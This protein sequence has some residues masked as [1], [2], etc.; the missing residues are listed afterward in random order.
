MKQYTS[1]IFILLGI[2]VLVLGACSDY[3]EK[4]I[5]VSGV[6]DSYVV[7]GN[8]DFELT[9]SLDRNDDVTI[10]GLWDDYDWEF[11]RADLDDRG[12]GTIDF[13]IRS[14]QV[15]GGPRLWGEGIWINGYFQLDYKIDWGPETIRYRM[16]ANQ[17]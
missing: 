9:I 14:Q 17:Y 13:D 15:Y 8:Y 3:D 12:D 7:N 5:A 2:Y 10:E 11:V 4:A 16:I 6:Y 1:K